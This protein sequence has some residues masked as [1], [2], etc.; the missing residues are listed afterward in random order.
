MSKAREPA[1]GRLRLVQ[2]FVNTHDPMSGEEDL[3][4]PPELRSWLV[5]RELLGPSEDVSSRDVAAARRVREGLRDL[6]RA[7]NR[8]PLAPASLE[9]LDKAARAARLSLRF[10]PDGSTTVEPAAPGVDGALGRL[11]VIVSEA[12][13][14]GSWSRLKACGDHECAWAFYD[15]SRN[16]S[17][18]WCS[19][20][21]C[22]NRA[23][24][25]AYRERRSA[26]AR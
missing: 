5:E 1:P 22:G 18:A 2:D 20:A 4:G 12:M 13:R 3:P 15:S 24:A 14:D 25:R 9:L 19:M 7:N 11:L 6:L 16:R 8:G 10:T 17:S 26:E 21:V 23:K